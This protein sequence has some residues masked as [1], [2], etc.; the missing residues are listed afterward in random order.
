VQCRSQAHPGARG[1]DV[2]THSIAQA[3]T[4]GPKMSCDIMCPGPLA[5]VGVGVGPRGGR[6]QALRPV[7]TPKSLAEV[8]LHWSYALL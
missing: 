2:H 6:S 4:E 5:G 1:R 8:D 3:G 7:S